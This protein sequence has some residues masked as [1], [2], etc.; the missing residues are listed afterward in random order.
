MIEN[1]RLE[2]RHPMA[3]VTQRTGLT[4]HALRAWERR[5]GVVSPARSSGGHRLYSDRDVER[6]RMLHRLKLGGRQIGQ[7]A[8]LSDDELAELLVEDDR[9]ADEA[10]APPEESADVVAA[11]LEGALRAVERMD[12]DALDAIL[13]RAAI[14]LETTTYLDHL[15]GPLLGAIGEAWAH[16]DISTAHEHLASA[17]IRRVSDWLL[18]HL[19]ATAEAGVIVVATLQGHRH[20][21]GA[22]AAAITAAAAG[23]RVRYLGAD[24]PAEDIAGAAFDSDAEAVAISL[25]YPFGDRGIA[26]ELRTLRERLPRA[27]PILVGGAAT[28]SYEDAL[29]EIGAIRFSSFHGLRAWLRA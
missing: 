15:V 14:T 7:I 5:Y 29:D 23:R 10:P 13:R 11:S 1:D 24:L 25:V 9:A 21:L 3:V 6:L 16:N 12:G 2:P 4:S 18:D 17:V 20:E 27:L 26:R 22:F 19:E 28:S 8:E